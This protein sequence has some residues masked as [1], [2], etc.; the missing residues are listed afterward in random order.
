MT[1]DAFIT[2][3]K[4]DLDNARTAF[5]EFGIN[6]IQSWTKQELAKYRAQPV[7]IPIGDYRFFV[8]PFQILGLHQHCWSVEQF[9]GKFIVP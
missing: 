7:V 3:R 8:G 9:D 1:K 2:K 6:Y 5:T 4:S